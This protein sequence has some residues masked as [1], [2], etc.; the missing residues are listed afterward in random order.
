MKIKAEQLSIILIVI[1]LF[2]VSCS[3]K[4]TP[5]DITKQNATT[6]PQ[7]G[8]SNQFAQVVQRSLSSYIQLPGEFKPFELV[9]IYPK[10]NGFVKNVFVDRGSIVKKGDVLIT[11]EAPEIDQQVLTAKAELAKKNEIYLNTKDRY[12][13]L[14]LA[15]KTPGAV[16]PYELT[17]AKSKM[18]SDS[19]SYNAQKASVA[20]M[21]VNHDYLTVRAP[22]DGVITERNIHPGALVGPAAKNNQ[23]PM[24]VL[25]QENKLRL[26]VNIPET[27]SIDVN[28]N[29]KVEFELNALPGK[30]FTASISRRAGAIN[31]DMRSETV[32]IDVEGNEDIKPGMYAEVKIPLVSSSRSY[33]VPSSAVVN[34]TNGNYVVAIKDDKRRKFVTVQEGMNMKDSVEIF[35]D[36]QNIKQVMKYPSSETTEDVVTKTKEH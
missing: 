36:L 25:Q 19:E 33:V 26:I 30:T 4:N 9:D 22:F 8:K 24:L 2:A 31:D 29:G 34:S 10:A 13:R 5:V 18:E 17:N 12:Q 7:D 15:S 3:S 35:G 27:A 14:L 23:L 16:A 11:L 20:A 28:K 21:A 1:S 6:S 32:E